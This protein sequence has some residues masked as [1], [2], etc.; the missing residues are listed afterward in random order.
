MKNMKAF[1]GDT[2]L[3]QL[4]APIVM[5]VRGPGGAMPAMVPTQPPTAEMPDPPKTFAQTP[6]IE[7]KIQSVTEDGETCCIRY[8][9][10][11]GGEV[12][13]DMPCDLILC[14]SRVSNISMAH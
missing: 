1:V 6:L 10:P 7:G 9:A 5:C 4:K 8:P 12:M 13:V 2:V 11:D 3:L 14:I